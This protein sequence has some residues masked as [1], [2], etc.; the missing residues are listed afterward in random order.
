MFGILLNLG[1]AYLM[2]CHF[3]EAVAAFE[4]A[5]AI[6]TANSILYFRWS[7]ALSYDEL[8]SLERLA[9][10][11]DLVR[12]AMECYAR[13]KIFR[14]QGKMVLKMLNLHNAAEAFE[15]QRSF[16]ESQVRHKENEAVATI[17]GN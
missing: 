7:Q 10:A 3:E 8:A 2:S 13:E 12:K 11:Q 14:E 1:T 16:V 9:I 15:Y 5:H 4:E 17:A 6:H